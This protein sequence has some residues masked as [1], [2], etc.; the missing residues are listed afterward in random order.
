MKYLLKLL[1]ALAVLT[2]GLVLF[3]KGIDRLYETLGKR[4][5]F[6]EEFTKV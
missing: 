3:Y 4:Y 6:H 2:G 1:A 5:V